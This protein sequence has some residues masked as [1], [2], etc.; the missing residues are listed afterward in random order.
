MQK[1]P[2]KT[3][4]LDSTGSSWPSDDDLATIEGRT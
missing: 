3:V 4:V 1:A 2:I